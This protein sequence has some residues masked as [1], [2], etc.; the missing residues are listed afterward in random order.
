MSTAAP[1]VGAMRAAVERVRDRIATA[2]GDPARVTVVAVTKGHGAA[3]ARSALAAGVSD[4]GENY[5]Q[6][7]LAKAPAVGSARWHFIG[8][9][10]R[11]KARALAPLVSCWQ[12]VDR[13]SVAVGRGRR[14]PGGGGGGPGKGC[15]HPPPG[16][17]APP[18]RP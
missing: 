14:A 12:T 4:L 5:A 16:G 11:N 15:A 10:Q 9:L 6:E 17:G 1:D 3:A 8:G 2:G 18:P 13:D 7:L